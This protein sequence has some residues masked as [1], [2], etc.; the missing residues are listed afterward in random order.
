MPGHFCKEHQ[1]VWFMK[2]KMKGYAHPIK[3]KDGNTIEWCNEPEGEKLDGDKL[4]PPTEPGMRDEDKKIIEAITPKTTREAQTQRSITMSY[5]SRLLE[6]KAIP[7]DKLLS[8]A[9]VMNR[10][11][12]GQIEVKDPVVFDAMV[13]KYFIEEGS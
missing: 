7:P 12:L 4:P 5:A 6:S 11:I 10:W 13:A 1:T 2:G 3:D 8:Y 9:E